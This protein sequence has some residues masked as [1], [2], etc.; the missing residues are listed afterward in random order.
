MKTEVYDIKKVFS[1][2]LKELRKSAHYTQ[3]EL[4]NKI[5][6]SEKVISK[7]EQ[8]RSI[9]S[10]EILYKIS[11]VLEVNM[12]S[13][14]KENNSIYYLGIDGGGTKTQF[15]LLDESGVEINRINIEGCNPCDIGMN[16]TEEILKKGFRTICGN[17]N[18][19]NVVLYAGIAGGGNTKNKNK[20]TEFFQGFNLKKAYN[21]SDLDSLIYCGLKNNDGI[22]IIMGTGV[23]CYSIINRRKRRIAGWGYLFDDGGSGYDLGRDVIKAFFKTCDGLGEETVLSEMVLKKCNCEVDKLVATVYENGKRYIASYAPL[24]FD[25]VKKNDK[26]S[27]DILNRNMKCISELIKNASKDFGNRNKINVVFAGGLSKND[28]ALEYLRN[29]IENIEKYNITVFDTEPAYACAMYAKNLYETEEKS[30]NK[31][32]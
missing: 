32:F 29:N 28:V 18:P 3:K 5:F 7:W 25:G 17:I 16:N 30:K 23:S 6:C 8:G 27:I 12:D 1:K 22:I 21:G 14:F 31:Q 24:V 20:L 2:N 10:V 11:S 4:G 19:K 26:V 9:P 15:S 13:F